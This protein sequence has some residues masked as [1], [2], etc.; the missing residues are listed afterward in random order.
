MFSLADAEGMENPLPSS[1]AEVLTDLSSHTVAAPLD[2]SQQGC[3]PRSE[4]VIQVRRYRKDPPQTE[5]TLHSLDPDVM[6]H[7]S[8]NIL[9]TRFT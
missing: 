5:I 2:Y 7:H 6:S 8:Q 1:L 3:L 4:Q 9:F